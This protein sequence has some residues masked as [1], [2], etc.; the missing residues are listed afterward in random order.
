MGDSWVTIQLPFSEEDITEALLCENLRSYLPD[1]EVFFPVLRYRDRRG[2]YVYSLFDGYCFVRGPYQ[3]CDYLRLE[4]SP[5]VHQVLTHRSSGDRVLVAY[6]PNGEIDVLREKL[7]ALVPSDFSEGDLVHITQ[8]IYR[9]L[10]G[11]IMGVDGDDMLVEVYMPVG[12]I[13]KLTTI[14][15]MFLELS[16]D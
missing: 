1:L 16:D 12:S 10:D 7:N 15:K 3:A 4:R 6:T 14:P 9:D 13:T 11:K 2:D 8:G 5:Y